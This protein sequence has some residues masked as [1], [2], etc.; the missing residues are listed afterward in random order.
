MVT[1]E[2][3]WYSIYIWRKKQ[4]CQ[5]VCCYD[6]YLL[7]LIL[8]VCHFTSWNTLNDLVISLIVLNY[9]W[10]VNYFRLIVVHNLVMYFAIPHLDF[11]SSS[12]GLSVPKIN[13]FLELFKIY[14]LL[15]NS[16][17]LLFFLFIFLFSCINHSVGFC[18]VSG[19]ACRCGGLFCGM[20]RYS[21]K[22]DCSFN[23]KEL[24]QKE[25]RKSNPVVVAEKIQKIW[26]DDVLSFNFN[27]L[28]EWLNIDNFVIVYLSCFKCVS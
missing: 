2:Y 21:D 27:H 24:A 19:F 5:F 1:A 7:K 20:H 26:W 3:C 23:Y 9:M 11:M 13:D 14:L 18:V 22:H 8:M 17:Q 4:A 28:T 10:T 25:I 6:T 15:T 16:H 12:L